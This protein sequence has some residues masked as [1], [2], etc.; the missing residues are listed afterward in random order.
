[1][2]DR[3]LNLPVF[4]RGAKIVGNESTEISAVNFGLRKGDEYYRI[5]FQVFTSSPDIKPEVIA[6]RFKE[7]SDSTVWIDFVSRNEE[8]LKLK[9]SDSCATRD[10]PAIRLCWSDQNLTLELYDQG[11]SYNLMRDRGPL[12]SE[13]NH[14]KGQPFTLKEL[15][16]R[17]RIR[18]YKS[19]EE[20]ISVFQA[21]E[22]ISEARGNLLPHLNMRDV[23]SVVTEGPLGL[24]SSVGDLLP[25]IFPTSWNDWSKSR[26]LYQAEILSFAALLAN[27]MNTVEGF[28][29]VIHRDQAM[30]LFL[31]QQINKLET[32]QASIKKLEDRGA[33][34]PGSTTD[35]KLSIRSIQQDRRQLASLIEKELAALA[36]A[37]ALSPVYQKIDIAS[38]QLPDLLT[39]NRSPSAHEFVETAK[40]RSLELGTLYFMQ[41]AAGVETGQKQFGFLDPNSG[42]FFGA[43][44][45]SSIRIAGAEIEKLKIR[46]LAMETGLERKSVEVA[47][48]LSEAIDIYRRANE[49]ATDVERRLDQVVWK[50][51]ERGAISLNDS[52]ILLQ[53]IELFRKSIEFEASRLSSAHAYLIAESKLNRLLLN[54]FYEGLEV[55]SLPKGPSR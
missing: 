18:N 30:L 25:F 32:I 50:P 15:V 17:A 26:E 47:A 40:A 42:E 36:E 41:E 34:Q 51:L 49:G 16:G 38:I 35:F 13:L 10:N 21:K 14:T 31:D 45:S 12:S 29:Y 20:A 8:G 5:R 2:K 19:A 53:V 6:L 28:Y 43:G 9:I 3:F 44:Y 37:V 1:M 54:G 33:L 23:V 55:V 11:V 4:Y 39:V 27:E 48:D 52:K 46:T 7:D 22:K 24:I